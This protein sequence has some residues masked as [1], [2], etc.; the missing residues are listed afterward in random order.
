MP[1]HC[2]SARMHVDGL[3]R[4]PVRDASD[5]SDASDALDET[6]LHR[7]QQSLLVYDSSG[8]AAGGQ[9]KHPGSHGSQGPVHQMRAGTLVFPASL[10]TD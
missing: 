6:A 10:F 4:P 3:S 2:V 9:V 5:A 7:V 8:L 1:L